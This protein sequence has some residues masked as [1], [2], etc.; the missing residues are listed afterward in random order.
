MSRQNMKKYEKK[1]IFQE[2]NSLDQGLRDR[3]KNKYPDGF[4]NDLIS[5][6]DMSGE[7]ITVLPFETNDTFYMLQVSKTNTM[8]IVY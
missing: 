3:I 7:K 8:K 6:I 5:Y 1:R 2:F 4:E